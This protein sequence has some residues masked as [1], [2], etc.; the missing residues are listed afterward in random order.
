MYSDNCFTILPLSQENPDIEIIKFLDKEGI[1]FFITHQDTISLGTER[2]KYYF[3][4]YFYSYM[5]EEI[6]K[7]LK[8]TWKEF[9]EILYENKDILKLIN[10]FNC[11]TVKKKCIHIIIDYYENNDIDKVV[12][13]DAVI[14]YFD[15]EETKLLNILLDSRR[16]KLKPYVLCLKTRQQTLKWLIDYYK[17]NIRFKSLVSINVIDV[18]YLD[19]KLTKF[20]Y[21]CEQM[22]TLFNSIPDATLNNYNFQFPSS[23]CYMTDVN[24]GFLNKYFFLLHDFIE[25]SILNIIEISKYIDSSIHDM[26]EELDEF[27]ILSEERDIHILK[28]QFFTRLKEKI[29]SIVYDD[30]KCLT[31]YCLKSK[32]CLNTLLKNE[33]INPSFMDSILTNML[34]F[35]NNGNFKIVFDDAIF[36]LVMRILDANNSITKSM[37][38][39]VKALSLLLKHF[40]ILETGLKAKILPSLDRYVLN[41]SLLF[42]QLSTYDNHD[43][44]VYYQ[45]LV[46][47]LS[48]YKETIY[49]VLDKDS[50]HKFIHNL[51]NNYLSF[52]K[53]FVQNLKRLNKAKQDEYE[54]NHYTI[55]NLKL[56]LQWYQ[57]EILEM[58]NFIISDNFLQEVTSAGIR[59]SMALIIGF[60]L[61]SLVGPERNNLVIGESKQ[62]FNP[63]YHV[64][65][66]FHWINMLHSNKDFMRTM[67]N[68]TRYTKTEYIR[69]LLDILLKKMEIEEKDS[70]KICKFI[71]HIDDER[72]KLKE[73]EEDENIPDELLDPIMG[74]LIETPI[75]LPVSNTFMEKDVI[76]RHL[77]NS[78]TNPFTRDP[79]TSKEL[80]EYNQREDVQERISSFKQR[81]CL[82]R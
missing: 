14:D 34:N 80:E 18:Y 9:V 78:A 49:E 6:T 79:L 22:L 25:L 1:S 16:L 21:L 60:K 12:L 58:D 19:R 29:N 52:Y 31:F 8:E 55:E 75:L 42:V 71:T 64:K 5:F 10:H 44:F 43:V 27:D 70:V 59:D 35:L 41:L 24:L 45:T 4:N 23:D 65:N 68:E 67:V 81:L 28:I 69:K 40:N 47:L 17:E 61:E 11:E 30:S 51:L 36:D 3:N 63:I 76:M 48:P 73:I 77:L 72:K 20:T 62:Y 15:I 38:V 2:D 7:T 66:I 33:N 57:S 56:Q 39:K 13:H 32:L 53:G 26:K 50:I 54:E 74:T 46:V 82:R 37:S